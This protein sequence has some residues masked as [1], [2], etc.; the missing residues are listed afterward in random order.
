MTSLKSGVSIEDTGKKG[1]YMFAG[2]EAMTCF[3]GIKVGKFNIPY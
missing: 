2:K 3:E 1:K